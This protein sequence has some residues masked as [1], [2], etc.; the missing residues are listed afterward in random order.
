MK[1]NRLL[2]SVALAGIVTLL[3][4]GWMA[5]ASAETATVEPTATVEAATAAPTATAEAATAV[6]TA[7]AET[8]T[9]APTVTATAAPTASAVPVTPEPTASPKPTTAEPTTQNSYLLLYVFNSKPSI[10]PALAIEGLDAYRMLLTLLPDDAYFAYEALY[11]GID[12]VRVGWYQRKDVD[13]L[14]SILKNSLDDRKFSGKLNANDFFDLLPRLMTR[15]PGSSPVTI[16]LYNSL[17]NTVDTEDWNTTLDTLMGHDSQIRLIGFPD[18]VTPKNLETLQTLMDLL[19]DATEGM[20]AGNN[21]LRELQASAS[22]SYLDAAFSDI[23]QILIER[24]HME[25]VDAV[26]TPEDKRTVITS[27]DVP[28]RGTQNLKLLLRNVPD[29]LALYLEANG[30]ETRLSE[31]MSNTGEIEGTTD[32]VYQ[33]Q[34]SDVEAVQALTLYLQADSEATDTPDAAQAAL[35]NSDITASFYFQFLLDAASV[36]LQMDPQVLKNQPFRI[37][38]SISDPDM[39]NDIIAD[40]AFYQPFIRCT[41]AEG[42]VYDFNAYQNAG[43]STPQLVADVVLPVSG[44]YTIQSG[45]RFQLS[46]PRDQLSDDSTA[47]HVHLNNAAPAAT[48]TGAS[49]ELLVDAPAPLS[50]GESSGS[51]SMWD[52][53]TDT[54]NATNTL[55][56]RLTDE[57][58]ETFAQVE[59]A[60]YQLVKTGLFTAAC[61]A[62]TGQLMITL[63]TDK[64]DQAKMDTTFYLVAYDNESA[65]ASLPI[66]VKLVD[67][68]A[69]ME[70]NDPFRVSVD[71]QATAEEASADGQ[72]VTVTADWSNYPEALRVQMPTLV[73]VN[74]CAVPEGSKTSDLE[75]VS[76]VK[77][78]ATS[79]NT[80]TAKLDNP[81]KTGTFHVALQALCQKDTTSWSP[82]DWLQVNDEAS[83][84][85]D[86]PAP[87]LSQGLEPKAMLRLDMDGLQMKPTMVSYDLSKAFSTQDGTQQ[88]SYDVA[89]EDLQGQEV[90]FSCLLDASNQVSAIAIGC[91]TTYLQ[92]ILDQYPDLKLMTKA[93]VFNLQ[94]SDVIKRNAVAVGQKL[95]ILY[96]AEGT[97]VVL[98]SARN[99]DSKLTTYPL[100]MY[101]ESQL[102]YILGLVAIGLAALAVLLAIALTLRRL[103]KPTYGNRSLTLWL[104]SPDFGSIINEQPLLCWQKRKIKLSELLL[105]TN[106]PAQAWLDDLADAIYLEPESGG[107]RVIADKK[108]LTMLSIG[109]G[110]VSNT[111]NRMSEGTTVRIRANGNSS[112]MLD[113]TLKS[114]LQMPTTPVNPRP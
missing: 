48:K 19:P 17:L 18:E 92:S 112:V 7:T 5:M 15:C 94:K 8:V 107:L 55:T 58:P 22:G 96:G 46:T 1:R 93:Q 20:M 59:N 88:L 24:F 83:F 90:D 21:K 77:A 47:L 84:V 65:V 39:L 45:V 30:T 101:V 27:T 16:L 52:F 72:Q 108:V 61:D 42:N 99:V 43:S 70:G 113:I 11:N 10:K 12:N 89:V 97:D 78:D 110:V 6:P 82:S 106:F 100:T 103:L 85:V 98:F 13:S 105:N 81:L 63:L 114:S 102:R 3:C 73:S 62:A 26:V 2:L 32:R 76:W 23:R 14:E 36:P 56:Y 28:M 75:N 74:V 53:F 95:S 33:L 41:D 54:D 51:I 40:S 44:D 64:L 69:W 34:T 109:D 87:I 66:T 86:Y 49:L 37:A 80:W 79:D 68:L 111:V 104:A 9:A 50:A 60:S 67:V 91:S 31:L 57:R 4:A 35:T 29:G 25:V 38:V 71:Q